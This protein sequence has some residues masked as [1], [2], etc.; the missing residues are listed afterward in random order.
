M[1]NEVLE[2][3]RKRKTLILTHMNSIN[4]L[5]S[6]IVELETYGSLRKWI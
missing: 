6:Q 1:N 5:K 2:E 3:I 4:T